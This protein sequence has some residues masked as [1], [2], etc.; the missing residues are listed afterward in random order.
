MSWKDYT[1]RN[2]QTPEDMDSLCLKY[3][4]VSRTEMNQRFVGD[5]PRDIRILEVGCGSGTNLELLFKMGFWNLYGIDRQT[6]GLENAWQLGLY[7]VSYGEAEDIPF[8]DGWFDL[9]FTSGLLIHIPPED[10][11]KVMD[12]IYRVSKRYIWGLEYYWPEITEIESYRKKYG[13]GC[14]KGNYCTLFEKMGLKR[15]L[16][17]RYKYLDSANV[18][19][20][21]LMMK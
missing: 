19:E 7:R 5:L 13:M 14:W 9:V 4:G 20:C 18:D 21:F 16:V 15:K 10:L 12:E 3:Y 6:N 1:E 11:P 8:K 17:L 2:P